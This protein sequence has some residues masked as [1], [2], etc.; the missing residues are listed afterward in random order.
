[1]SI[2]DAPTQDGSEPTE[3]AHVINKDLGAFLCRC[4]RGGTHVVALAVLEILYFRQG[5]GSSSKQHFEI[6]RSQ[7][8]REGL[9]AVGQVIDLE[10]DPEY[11]GGQ[12]VWT[13]KYADIADAAAVPQ[14]L[15]ER[16]TDKRAADKRAKI[17]TT[18]RFS[19]T[20][21]A[22]RFRPLRPGVRLG[23]T[24][25]EHAWSLDH[26]QPETSAKELWEL[27]NPDSEELLVHLD[28]LP[29]FATTH[30]PYRRIDEAVFVIDGG[31]KALIKRG[32]DE[33]VPCLVCGSQ[34]KVKLMRNHVGGHILKAARGLLDATTS[35]NMQVSLRD[36]F[37]YLN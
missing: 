29:K 7:L 28:S 4:E 18:K 36:L 9:Y 37:Y 35:T 22:S 19:I 14:D 25:E 30:L 17:D 1:M 13:H 10:F 24:P 16:S 21:S 33:V 27:L 32:G 12:W 20:I 6:E 23:A 34:F 3:K 31:A 2:C 11:L 8:G 26:G 5:T 15:D